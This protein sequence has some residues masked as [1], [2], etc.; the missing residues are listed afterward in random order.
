MK[1]EKRIARRIGWRWATALGLSLT[2]LTG[3]MVSESARAQTRSREERPVTSLR[4]YTTD[5]TAAA[6]QGR[7]NSIDVPAEN[8]DRAIE[9]LTSRRKNNP[10]IIS[11]SQSNRDM[12]IIGVAVRIANGNVPDQLKAGRLYKLNLTALFKDSKTADELSSNL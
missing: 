4:K 7:F 3:I 10:V 12:V 1:R 5:L 9:I 2:L 6:E 8:A 11:D